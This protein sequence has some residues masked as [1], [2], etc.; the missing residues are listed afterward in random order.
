MPSVPCGVAATTALSCWLASVGAAEEFGGLVTGSFGNQPLEL[1]VS[2]DLS[3]AQVIGNHADASLIATLMNGPLGPVILTMTLSGALPDPDE[4]GLELAFA[5][6]MG[7]NWRGDERSLTLELGD[8][9]ASDGMLSLSGTVTGT[10]NGGPA[11]ATRPATF[12]FAA[13]LRQAGR[14]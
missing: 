5:R 3:D 11:A 4:V 8:Y 10:V 1:S 13:R 9:A 2:P 14:P 12:S 7:R 6:E